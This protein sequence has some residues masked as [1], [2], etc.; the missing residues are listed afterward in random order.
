MQIPDKLM[1]L[2]S[3]RQA[4][5]ELERAAVAVKCHEPWRAT[6]HLG[7]TVDKAGEA[8]QS[9]SNAFKEPRAGD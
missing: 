1:V 2:D 5:I 4:Q 6:F 8:V 7:V 3:I 9:L